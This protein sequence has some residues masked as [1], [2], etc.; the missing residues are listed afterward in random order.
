MYFWFL[1]VSS[2]CPQSINLMRSCKIVIMILG[3]QIMMMMHAVRQCAEVVSSGNERGLI[4]FIV[5]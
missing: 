5:F 1:Y 2:W 4:V 3:N